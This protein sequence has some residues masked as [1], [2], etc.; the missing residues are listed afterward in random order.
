M[1]RAAVLMSRD[2][3]AI[4]I[5]CAPFQ[6]L[7]PLLLFVRTKQSHRLAVEVDHA[8]VVTLRRRLDDL[9]RDSHDR[10][11]H[12]GTRYIEIHIST[13]QPEDLAPAHAVI[14]ASRQRP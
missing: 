8:S 3:V 12:R 9:V 2:E 14:A 13:T 4:P 5:A 6:P 11:S 7:G 10:L 1:N